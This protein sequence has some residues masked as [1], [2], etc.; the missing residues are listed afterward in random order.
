MTFRRKITQKIVNLQ[1][2]NRLISMKTS[3]SLT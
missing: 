2:K 3:M 1:L